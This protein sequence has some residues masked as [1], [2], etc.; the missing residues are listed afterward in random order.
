M[1]VDIAQIETVYEELM[2]NV[3]ATLTEQFNVGYVK[4]AD[5]ANV[6]SQAMTAAMQL[7]AMSVIEQPVKDA[8]LLDMK[9]KDFV[10]LA[11]SEIMRELLGQEELLVAA[12]VE[13]E[14]VKVISIGIE[15]ATKTAATDADVLIR[16]AQ[17]ALIDAQSTTETN[18]AALTVRQKTWFDDQKNIK[19]AE[20]IGQAAGMYGA[21]GVP[22]AE[23]SSTLATAIANIGGR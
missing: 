2:A 21:G 15:A 22:S 5:Y 17:K 8:Q 6:L 12:Q 11:E 18:K 13:T 10:A 7:A 9:V 19:K 20:I 23:L 14:G 3:E 4:G 16:T 1:A